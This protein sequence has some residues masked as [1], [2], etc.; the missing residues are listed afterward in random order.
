MIH[1]AD[2]RVLFTLPSADQTIIGTTETP[3][4]LADRESRASREEVAYLLS[5]A[6]AYFP[7]A[8]LATS[9]VISTWSGIRPLARQ[10]ATGDVG[11]ASREHTIARGPK[12]VVHVTGGKLTT[13]REMASQVVDLFAGPEALPE[14][15]ALLPLPG[16]E[17][18]VD[19]LRTDAAQAIADDE[20]RDR[21]VLAHGSRWRNLW[22]LGDDR[23][24]L[25]ERLSPQI[26]VIGAEFVYGAQREM[27]M[28]LGDLLIR[29]THLAFESRD[30]ARS[31]APV[32]ADL[33]APILGWTPQARVA[34]LREYDAEVS[35]TFGS[36][37]HLR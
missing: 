16:G 6:N 29:R 22:A 8:M 20:V 25:R 15:T 7:G 28:T 17:R 2:G 27:A 13:Y 31:I 26:A 24:E 32:V 37:G 11:S 33:V 9:D 19:E 5:A 30:Q 23:P 14:R 3:T 18:S 10:L 35:R 36:G 4:G 1:P 21:L 12:G 34:A